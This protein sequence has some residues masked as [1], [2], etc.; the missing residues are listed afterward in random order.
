MRRYLLDTNIVSH[1]NTD[2]G[3]SRVL[4]RIAEVGED[5]V[6]TSI[7]VAAEIRYGVAMKGSAR[8]RDAADRVLTRLAIL[9]VEMPV[10]DSHGTV[11]S[12]RERR[13]L[14]I[15]PNDLLIAS[16]CLSLGLILVTNNTR[17]FA[18]VAGLAVEDWL[19]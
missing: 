18:R 7:I 10:D 15:G 8:L 3:E 5:R 4:A 11:R 19:S 9:P 6:C 17:E 16:Q 1:L 12:D 13:G 2:R 14:M